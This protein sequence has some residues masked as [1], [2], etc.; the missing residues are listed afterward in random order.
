MPN[1]GGS[2][3][4]FESHQVISKNNNYEMITQ[5][6]HPPLA[7][8]L[9]G[10]LLFTI[11]IA[12]NATTL[13]VSQDSYIEGLESSLDTNF[14]AAAQVRVGQSGTTQGGRKAYFLFDATGLPD[15]LSVENFQIQR[16]GGTISR[17]I[18]LYAILGE[19]ANSWTELGITWNNAPGNNVAP[20]TRNFE[21]YPGESLIF[22]DTF[23]TG[24]LSD[25]VYN[26]PF[27]KLAEADRQVILNTLNTGDRKLTLG[28]HYNSS[29]DSTV[30]FRSQ[31]NGDGS[32]GA[33]LNL[34]VDE[35]VIETVKLSET[36]DQL[37]LTGS[38]GAY[39]S[40]T[41]HV[42]S[43][44]DP[45]LPLSSWTSIATNQFQGGSFNLSIPLDPTATQRFYKLQV[46]TP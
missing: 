31:E 24:S 10:A 5:R 34:T 8:M 42:L 29:Q 26:V 39:L 33:R 46:P 43:S 41:F 19:N 23:S 4:R 16:A 9:A 14:G 32:F 2:R 40:E 13:T 1:D 30:N 21:A 36:G 3:A 37:E 6:Y 25:T 12:S 45:V 17:T 7:T 44:P 20:G 38:G 27:G 11:A 22:I 28:L 35:V 18:A 15:I